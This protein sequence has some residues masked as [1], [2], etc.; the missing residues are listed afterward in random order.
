MNEDER[1]Q[2]QLTH[3]K[4]IE[5]ELMKTELAI[6]NM[7][8]EMIVKFSSRDPVPPDVTSRYAKLMNSNQETLNEVRKEISH[9]LSTRSK[10]DAHVEDMLDIANALRDEQKRIHVEERDLPTRSYMTDHQ[11][12][13]VI[14]RVLKA[15]F[16]QYERA[17]TTEKRWFES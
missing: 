1:K 13:A 5:A 17:E 11:K 8:D 15:K 14:R 10:L 4:N 2:K 12:R 3:L 7:G 16:K 9:L 6:Q